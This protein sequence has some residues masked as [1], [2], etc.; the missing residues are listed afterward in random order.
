MAMQKVEVNNKAKVLGWLGLSYELIRR[1]LIIVFFRY[2]TN[3][4]MGRGVN[5]LHVRHQKRK[6]ERRNCGQHWA[7]GVAVG[8]YFCVP[9]LPSV[10]QK[11]RVLGKWGL[12]N[13]KLFWGA[14]G[15]NFGGNI[16]SKA[17]SG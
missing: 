2:G 4:F 12:Y 10:P 14:A 1:D 17:A 8:V 16:R 6:R 11:G 9:A 13:D 5:M 15:E 3:L 7:A